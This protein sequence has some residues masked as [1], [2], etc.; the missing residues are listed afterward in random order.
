MQL[1]AVHYVNEGG[2]NG[3]E[4]LSLNETGLTRR[5]TDA[6]AVLFM[7]AGRARSTRSVPFSTIHHRCVLLGIC[8]DRRDARRVATVGSR[9]TVPPN[10]QLHSVPAPQRHKF[11]CVEVL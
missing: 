5:G 9:A 4:I 1:R 7:A 2:R 10:V 3:R 11:R 6:P 8:G